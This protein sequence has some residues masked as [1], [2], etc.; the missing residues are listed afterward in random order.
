[1]PVT[2]DAISGALQEPAQRLT[3]PDADRAAV[4]AVL[5]PDLDLLFIERA[6]WEGDPW[7]G[8]VSFPGGRME[9]IDPDPLQAAIRET[10]EELGVTLS[11]AMLLGELDEVPTIAP[12]PRLLVRPHVFVL[13]ERPLVVPNREV[14]AVHLRPL[15]A[16]LA[17]V[18]RGTMTYPFQGHELTLPCVRFDGVCLW[19]L[20]L[21]MVDDLLHR[22]D[23]RG[24]GLDRPTRG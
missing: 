19:G 13:P 22:L 12:L 8:H 23:G 21:R 7:S 6:A 14:A 4:S 24:L 11:P 17:G 18:G 5:T 16:L 20:T 1:M 10:E 2:L 15:E 9:P 3:F